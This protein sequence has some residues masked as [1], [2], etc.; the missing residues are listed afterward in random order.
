LYCNNYIVDVP[1]FLEG[2]TIPIQATTTTEITTTPDYCVVQNV[3]CQNGGACENVDSGWRCNCIGEFT[4]TYC[5]QGTTDKCGKAILKIRR[6][7]NKLWL[8][9]CKLCNLIRTT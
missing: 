8:I 4:G 3:V 6:I 2:A 7:L 5:E 9:T 1:F